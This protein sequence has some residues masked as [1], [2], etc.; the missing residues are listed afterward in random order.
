MEPRGPTRSNCYF[1][2][3]WQWWRRGGYLVKRRSRFSRAIPHYLWSR[4]LRTFW[5]YSPIKPKRP[6]WDFLWFR[7][8]VHRGDD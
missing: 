6:P 8:R 4:D 2:A 3:R 5:S 7:G 1:W